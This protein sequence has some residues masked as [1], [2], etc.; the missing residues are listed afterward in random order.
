[1]IRKKY[2]ILLWYVI[3]HSLKLMDVKL[4][5]LFLINGYKLTGQ[6]IIIYGRT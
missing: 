4:W 6:N 3:V 1:M 5:F 2:T